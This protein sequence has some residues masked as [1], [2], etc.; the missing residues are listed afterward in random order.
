LKQRMGGN[1][2]IAREI[3]EADIRGCFKELVCRYW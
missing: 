3:Y 1:E 2:A